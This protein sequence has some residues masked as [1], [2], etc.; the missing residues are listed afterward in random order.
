MQIYLTNRRKCLFLSL[1][2]LMHC[3]CYWTKEV[4]LFQENISTLPLLL[5]KVKKSTWAIYSI[6]QFIKY[7][8]FSFRINW[9]SNTATY[10]CFFNNEIAEMFTWSEI[11]EIKKHK[12]IL[13]TSAV[14]ANH[15]YIK[16]KYKLLYK[17]KIHTV[18]TLVNKF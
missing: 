11:W 17:L 14:H 6:F 8:F 18:K 13:K 2:Y 7:I 5:Y 12:I 4:V 15:S 9:K 3:L 1:L 10:A 16:S